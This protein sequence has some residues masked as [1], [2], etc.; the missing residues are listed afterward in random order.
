LKILFANSSYPPHFVAGAERVVQSLA[1]ALVSRGHQAVV[2]TTQPGGRMEVA[3][4]NG[5]KVYYLPIANVYAPF[6][7]KRPGAA[8]RALWHAVDSYNP[9]MARAVGKVLDTESPNVVNTHNLVGL[10]CAV[11]GSIKDRGLPLVHTLHDQYLLCPRSTMFKRDRNCQRLCLDCRLY[12]LPRRVASSRVDVVVGVSRFILQRHVDF[13]Y[14]RGAEPRVIYNGV[15]DGNHK[16]IRRQPTPDGRLRFGFLGQLR[17]T[18]GLHQLV[19]AFAAECA[20]EAELWIAGHGDSNYEAELRRQT[21]EMTSVRW[22]G[23]V[24]PCELLGNVDVLVVPSLWRDTAPLVLLEALVEGMPVIGSNRGGIPEFISE[25]TGWV[26]EPD[27]AMALRR[28]LRACL[29]SRDR[30]PDMRVQAKRVAESFT[31]AKFVEGYLDAYAAAASR[32]R[33]VEDRWR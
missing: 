29:V 19:S 1:E 16:R 20:G 32:A 22:L 33:P 8:Q 30:L 21:A 6:R 12:A 2:V 17:P 15:G 5:V 26:Y 13:G 25:S 14:F 23:F 11:I 10:S 27:D 7:A 9:A 18:K 31:H 24:Q 28:A 4:L 3:E